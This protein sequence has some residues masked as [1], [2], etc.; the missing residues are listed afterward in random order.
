[1]RMH[2]HGGRP[3]FRIADRS[4]TRARARGVSAACYPRHADRRAADPDG[5]SPRAPAGEDAPGQPDRDQG[6]LAAALAA[7]RFAEERFAAFDASITA[8]AG[9]LAVD[10]VLQVIVD[11]ARDL[12]GAAYAALGIVDGE[13]VIEQFITSGMSRLER[14]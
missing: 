10:R 13:G 7:V 1:M 4:R 14:S 3:G 12:V 5:P 2:A 9:I 11:R 6:N 8:M